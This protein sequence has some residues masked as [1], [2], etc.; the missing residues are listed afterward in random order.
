[1]VQPTTIQEMFM[2]LL[3]ANIILG[4]AFWTTKRGRFLSVTHSLI[5]LGTYCFLMNLSMKYLDSYYLHKQ[6]KLGDFTFQAMFYVNICLTLC[7]IPCSWLRRKVT[8]G[9]CR[10][11]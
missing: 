8:L 2:P 7:L 4:M 6:N 10:S 5:C 3:V 11:R 9:N 1:M